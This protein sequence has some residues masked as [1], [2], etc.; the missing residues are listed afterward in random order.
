MIKIFDREG[1]PLSI[2]TVVGRG[3]E[4]VVYRVIGRPEW[5]AKIYEPAPR[6]NYGAKLAWMLDHPPANPTHTLNHPSLAWPAGLLYGQGNHLAGYLMPYIQQAVPILV[7]FNPRRRVETL[8][9]FD[10]RYLHRA[11]RNLAIAIGALHTSGY[12]V[13][14]LNES[15][16]LVTPSALVTLIDTDSFQVQETRGGEVVTYACPVAKPEYTPP[17]LQGKSLSTTVRSPEQ[18]AFGLGVLIFQLL[19]EGNHPFRAQWLGKGDPPPIEARIA[20]GGFPYTSTPDVPVRPPKYAP[21]LD[22]LHPEISELVRRCFIDGHRDPRLRPDAFAW[23]KAIAEAEK[24]L[25]QCPNRHFYSEHLRICPVCHPRR[26]AA[27]S[28]PRATPASNTVFNGPYGYAQPR[29]GPAKSAN[30]PAASTKGTASAASS[31]AGGS[32]APGTKPKPGGPTSSGRP[33]GQASSGKPPASQAGSAT[34]S[35]PAGG[36]NSG[37][38]QVQQVWETLKFWQVQQTLVQQSAP[39]SG[40]LGSRQAQQAIAA[41]KTWKYW[42]A[43]QAQVQQPSQAP[44]QTAQH[45]QPP[46]ARPA[47]QAQPAPGS[48]GVAQSTNSATPPTGAGSA[49]QTQQP[50]AHVAQTG[51]KMAGAGAAALNPAMNTAAAQRPPESTYSGHAQPSQGSAHST[52]AQNTQTQSGQGQQNQPAPSRPAVQ[53]APPVPPATPRQ[54]APPHS[55][56]RKPAPSYA[57][58]Q[59]GRATYSRTAAAPAQSTTSL[60]NWAGPRLYKSVAIGGGLGALAGA[61]PGAL[62][63]VTGLNT[64]SMASWV[65]L[66]ALGGATAGLLRGWQPSYRMS[67]RVDQAIGWQRVWPAIGVLA[68][69]SL[70]GFIGLVLGWWAICPVFLGLLLGAWLG[71]KAGSKLWQAGA[72]LGW[73]R[74]WAGVGALSA[75]LLGYRVAAWLGAGSLSIQLAG[76]VSAWITSQSASLV[77]VSLVIGALGGALGGA[78]AGTFADLFARLFNLMN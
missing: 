51:Q 57:S 66:W 9:Q 29:T 71:R 60:L 43:Q 49:Q 12:V 55:K 77:L 18:D 4:A 22:M 23:E 25:V 74:I 44:Q 6:S 45:A 76:S 30:K 3:G 10:R 16:V 69:A 7:V 67:L 41:W 28:N 73:V 34:G 40:L 19:M 38:K 59:P 8:A 64:G 1:N 31:H 2:G 32:P 78:V 14:D 42:Q 50:G 70:G 11:A 37:F 65:L 17:E 26:A 62:V 33:A 63:G 53:P 35:F 75:A 52:P 61:L 48:P 68:G 46:P 39:G 72:Q 20:L 27:A 47:A 24:N 5:L 13:G 15:N 58:S 21:D 54:S 56:P 36:I